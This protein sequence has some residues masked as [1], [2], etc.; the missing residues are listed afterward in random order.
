[1]KG[2]RQAG[3]LLEFAIFEFLVF[4]TVCR[5][6]QPQDSLAKW[7]GITKALVVDL[8]IFEGKKNKSVY[9]FNFCLPL[10]T[11]CELHISS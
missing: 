6:K 11:G 1:M 4:I 10:E 9:S 7:L 5:T 8:Y 2:L 3:F